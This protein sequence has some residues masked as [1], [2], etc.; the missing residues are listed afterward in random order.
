MYVIK[1]ELVPFQVYTW[2][3]MNVHEK[4]IPCLSFVHQFMFDSW[5]DRVLIVMHGLK[6]LEVEK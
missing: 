4:G 2:G 5:Y 1:N 3:N 6:M